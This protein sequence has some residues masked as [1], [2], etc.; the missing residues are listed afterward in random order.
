[1][2]LATD[3]C[4]VGAGPAGLTLALLLLRSGA[5]VAV[6]ERSSTFSR[7]FRG[8]VLQPG[9]MRVLDE[10]GVLGEARERG[11]HEHDRFV[12]LE[13]G[14]PLLVSDY[15]ALPGPYACLLSVPQQHVLDVLLGRCRDYPKMAYLGGNRVRSLL[16]D[17]G[18]I[19]GLECGGPSGR[20]TVLAHC[21]VGADGRYSKVRQLA[22]IATL[23]LDAFHQDVLWF[24]VNGRSAVVRDVQVFRETDSPVIAYTS[25]PN[26]IQ[27]GWTLPHGGYAGLAEAGVAHIKHELRAAIPP[28]ADLIDD[29]IGSMRDLNLLDVFSAMAAEWVRDGLVLIGDS[30]HTHSPIGAQGLNLAIQDAVLVHPVLI[31][32]LRRRDASAEF[33]S[34][35]PRMR[36]PDIKRIARIQIMQSRMML[37]TGWLAARA[38]PVLA[39]AVSHSPV[40]HRVQRHLAFGNPR[41]RISQHLFT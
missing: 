34:S 2:E 12:L 3:F 19:R 36:Q 18:R 40:F 27:F 21:I 9:G 41:I 37:S 5:R 15:R 28:Y 39:R 6:V 32:S 20:T 29:E 16:T 38:R 13:R 11:C 22:G 7:D 33:L 25:H 1:M 14:R 31:E 26:M 23:R 10:L 17:R 4:I 30:A 24:K 35:F 8:E